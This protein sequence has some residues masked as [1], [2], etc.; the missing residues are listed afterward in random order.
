MQKFSLDFAASGLHDNLAT[1]YLKQN[2]SVQPF[3]QYPLTLDECGEAIEQRKKFPFHRD[4]LVSVLRQQYAEVAAIDDSVKKNIDALQNENTFT[5]TSGHQLCLFTG[6][7]YFVY[8]IIS[9]INLSNTLKEKFPAYH[10]VPVYWM[11]S[12]DHDFEEINHVHLFNKTLKWNLDAKGAAG[13]LPTET[14]ADV[15]KELKEILGESDQANQL[16][17][18]F[19]K[20]YLFNSNLADATRAL[21]NELFG[22]Y[23]LVIVDGNNHELKKLFIPVMEEELL[24]QTSFEKV[25][26]TSAA[27]EQLNYK[28]Q[29]HP[30]NINLFFLDERLRERIVQSSDGNYEV[31]NT[32]LKF[33]KDFLIDL[34]HKQPEHFS[35]NVVLRPA[36]EETILPNIA[37]VG[38]PGEI[39]YWLQYKSMFEHFHIHYPVLIL[40]SRVLILDGNSYKKMQSLN[41][42][43]SDLFKPY[44]TL[45]KNFVANNSK[46]PTGFTDETQQLKELFETIEQKAILTDPTLSSPIKAEQQKALN[47]IELIDKKVN[48]AIKRKHETALNQIKSL[49]EK[50]FPEKT[51]QERYQNLIPYYLKYG[52]GFIDELI[53]NSESFDFNL[54]VLVE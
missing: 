45:V 42:K 40:R 51:L 11:A 20:S 1:D 41:L 21:V 33:K 26:A 39:C 48:A 34:L 14:I 23:G 9:V 35:P 13:N 43:F 54:T 24:K 10:F 27:L 31:V 5:V 46:N 8:K 29:A 47:S 15:L 52:E 2:K 18:L 19:E 50:V 3:Y 28:P 32:D 4:T 36:Y 44:D 25:S 6:P 38:G 22:K 37:F 49:T 53:L 17:K 7:L 16:E 12:E 30:R